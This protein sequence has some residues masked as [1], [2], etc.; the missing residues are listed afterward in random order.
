MMVGAAFQ[1][2]SELPVQSDSRLESRSHNKYYK[3]FLFL[4]DTCQKK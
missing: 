1:P 2:R 4:K 3:C